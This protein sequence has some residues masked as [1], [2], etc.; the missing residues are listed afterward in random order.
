MR[1]RNIACRS[2][3]Q[4]DVESSGNGTACLKL[5]SGNRVD[6]VGERGDAQVPDAQGLKHQLFGRVL[7]NE[8]SL[9]GVDLGP[10]FRSPTLHVGE[11]LVGP[12]EAFG[13]GEP[14]GQGDDFLVHGQNR[15][16]LVAHILQCLHSKL[17]KAIRIAGNIRSL[18]RLSIIHPV[19]VA[20]RSL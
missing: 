16:V 9:F 3:G 10:I 8:P 17:D 18:V 11:Q 7:V 14:A 12:G 6:F 15:L 13:I 19:Q 4:L 5:Q 1:R 20:T 2:I